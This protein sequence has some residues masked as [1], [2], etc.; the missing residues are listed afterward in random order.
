MK[1]NE[2]NVYLVAQL[3]KLGAFLGG[4]RKQCAIVTKNADRI[5]VN[6]CPAA[7]ECWSIQR[8]KLLKVGSISNSADDFPDIKR[9][10]EVF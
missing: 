7:N 10:S 9:R 2:W 4:L 1:E 5:P 8:L 3:D 6:A